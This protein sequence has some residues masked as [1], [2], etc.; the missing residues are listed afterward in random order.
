MHMLLFNEIEEQGNLIC[1]T[2]KQDR[3]LPVV[4]GM[5]ELCG[6]MAMFS[7]L[8]GDGYHMDLCVY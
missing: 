8:C 5:R 3:L 7:V 6:V 4:V 1:G 2:G